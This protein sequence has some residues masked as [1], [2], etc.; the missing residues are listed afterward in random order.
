MER[1]S[2]RE[3]NGTSLTMIKNVGEIE[4]LGAEIDPSIIDLNEL[5]TVSKSWVSF[6]TLSFYTEFFTR[7]IFTH[8]LSLNF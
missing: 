3:R 4:R 2:D 8:F 5:K 6:Y 1:K 7:L